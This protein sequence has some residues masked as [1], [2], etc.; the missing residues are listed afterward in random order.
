MMK[1]KIEGYKEDINAFKEMLI[2]NTLCAFINN[3]DVPCLGECSCIECIESH[4][5]FIEKE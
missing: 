1:L 5:D 2:E 4:I 3:D